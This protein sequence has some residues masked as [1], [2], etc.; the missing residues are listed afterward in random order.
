MQQHMNDK[1]GSNFKVLF[2]LLLLLMFFFFIVFL[3]R[4]GTCFEMSGFQFLLRM[5]HL[6]PKNKPLIV[7]IIMP[8]W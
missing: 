8:E 6:M 1:W 3:S 7:T 2:A 5:I 4:L